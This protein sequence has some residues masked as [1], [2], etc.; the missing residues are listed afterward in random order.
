M[1]FREHCFKKRDIG[2]FCS[3]LGE[4]REKLGP[5]NCSFLPANHGAEMNY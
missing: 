3:K 2:E 4:F 5:L 1:L